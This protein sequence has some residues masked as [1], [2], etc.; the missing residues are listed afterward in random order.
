MH[1]QIAV[2]Q[3]RTSFLFGLRFSVIKSIFQLLSELTFPI[4]YT[5]PEHL[6][7]SASREL[8]LSHNITSIG[9][10]AVLS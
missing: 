3:V 6:V 1:S 9:N 2:A 5:T 7:R 10:T 8:L 4:N